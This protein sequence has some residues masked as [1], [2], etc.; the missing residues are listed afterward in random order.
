MTTLPNGKESASLGVWI[1]S[2][3]LYWDTG[4][5]L[6]QYYPRS[7]SKIFCKYF[8]RVDADRGGLVGI[9]GRF[10]ESGMPPSLS[11]LLHC[12]ALMAL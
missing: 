12:V 7:S 5:V 4:F 1:T 9:Y 3:F 11:Q 6:R 10:F 8:F 2:S